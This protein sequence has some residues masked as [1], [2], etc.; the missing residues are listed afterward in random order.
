MKLLAL[1]ATLA[2]ATAFVSPQA[3]R[4]ASDVAGGKDEL[5]TLAEKLNPSVKFCKIPKYS[6]L[7]FFLLSLGAELNCSTYYSFF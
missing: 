5:V 7:F 2:T 4:P 6:A 3:G 1:A